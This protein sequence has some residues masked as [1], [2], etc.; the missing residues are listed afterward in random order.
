LLEIS[1]YSHLLASTGVTAQTSTRIY[2]LMLPQNTEY[3]AQTYQRIST[4]PVNSLSGY[5]NYENARIQIDSWATGYS[6]VKTLARNTHKAMDVAIA[7]RA[8]LE[9]EEDTLDPEMNLYRVSQDYS[10]WQE[11]T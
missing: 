1:I 10:C 11:T 8:T 2:P 3:P 5:L 7:F 6:A 4:I 9:S